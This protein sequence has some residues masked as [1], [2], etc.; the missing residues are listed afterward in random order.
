MSF[1]ENKR[2]MKKHH[3]RKP[4]TQRLNS[5]IPNSPLQPPYQ[6]DVCPSPQAM[7][8]R[9]MP[10]TPPLEAYRPPP[11]LQPFMQ[12]GMSY[13]GPN[14]VTPS[15]T[16]TVTQASV[17]QA[18]PITLPAA[19]VSTSQLPSPVETATTGQFQVYNVMIC[20]RCLHSSVIIFRVCLV[21]IR[22]LLVI[23]YA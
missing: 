19:E 9:Q 18:M 15:S 4:S 16:I 5:H 12:A 13:A 7:L 1:L 20:F 3:Q 2:K 8:P 21:A 11:A 23:T 22:F 10:P 17:P 6:F 14:P